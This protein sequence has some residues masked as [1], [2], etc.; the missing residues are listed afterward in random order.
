M[1][2]YLTLDYNDN[3]KHSLIS[4]IFKTIFY[5]LIFEAM[6]KAGILGGGQLGRM[7]LQAAANYPVETY[8]LENDTTK[9]FYWFLSQNIPGCCNG[10]NDWQIRSNRKYPPGCHLA[11]RSSIPPFAGLFFLSILLLPSGRLLY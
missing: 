6:I 1:K 5:S 10:G 8:I 9:Q 2:K 4:E 11:E 7:L 3:Q